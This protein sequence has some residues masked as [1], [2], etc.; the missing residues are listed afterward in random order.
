MSS[1]LIYARNRQSF[2]GLFEVMKQLESFGQ[3]RIVLTTS[4]PAMQ[5]LSKSYRDDLPT[6]FIRFDES[7]KHRWDAVLSAHLPPGNTTWNGPLMIIPHGTGYGICS[8]YHEIV[9][10]H[11]SIYFGHHPAEYHYLRTRLGQTFKK[12]RFVP[13]GSPH[14]DELARYIDQKPEDRMTL[15]QE[16]GLEPDL[17]VILISS[18]WTPDSIL[19]TWGVDALTELQP[20]EEQFNIVQIGH[21][22]L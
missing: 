19:R 1:I 11:S 3:I 8:A 13:T 4:D 14:T 16:F 5:A 21:Q 6:R 7:L 10:S 12:D 2:A 9:A 22:L 20:F 17:P 15:K 18:H